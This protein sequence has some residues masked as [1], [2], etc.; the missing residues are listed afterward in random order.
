MR[1]TSPGRGGAVGVWV[2]GSVAEGRRVEVRVG[3]GVV[4]RVRDGM[5]VGNGV[6]VPRGIEARDAFLVGVPV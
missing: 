6:E 5:R 2:K 3:V 4:V 1:V